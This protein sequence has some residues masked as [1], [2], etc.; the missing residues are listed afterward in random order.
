MGLSVD[1]PAVHR[2]SFALGALALHGLLLLF[3][4][5]NIDGEAGLA[6]V[7]Q[8]EAEEIVFFVETVVPQVIEEKVIEPEVEE[9]IYEEVLE[10]TVEEEQAEVIE[11]APEK[12]EKPQPPKPRIVVQRP[13]PKPA[14]PKPVQTL[15]Q[16]PVQK[17]S[18]ARQV[19]SA[20]PGFVK[21]SFPAYL[22]NPPPN[23]PK[24]ARKRHMEGVTQLWVQISEKGLVLSLKVHKSSGHSRLDQEAVKAVRTWRFIPAKKQGY[25]VIGE[26]IVPIRFKLKTET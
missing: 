12:I 9:E 19:K 18:L 2:L 13:T 6:D 25:P 21:P 7:V 4:L 14:I 24:N 11:E 20:K 17:I 5:L 26:V 23:Y 3:F 22:K 1:L 16:K 8:P 15:V 10:D